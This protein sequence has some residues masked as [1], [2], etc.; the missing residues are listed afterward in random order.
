MLP[1]TSTAATVNV[2]P[3][4]TSVFIN[5]MTAEQAQA[6]FPVISGLPARAKVFVVVSETGQALLVANTRAEASRQVARSGCYELCT[7]H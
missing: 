4:M 6:R 7:C 5:P 3:P 2:V 1:V